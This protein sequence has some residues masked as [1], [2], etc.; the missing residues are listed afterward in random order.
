MISTTGE[1]A[2][3]AV[4]FLAQ[5]AGEAKTS[6][7]IADATKVPQGYLSKVMQQLAKADIVASQRGLH[8]GFTLARPPVSI[9]VLEVLKAVD[10]APERIHRCP[11]GIA[12]HTR[13]CPVH[14]LV[15]QAMAK[16]EAAFAKS[17]LA[18]L[19]RSTEGIQALC[20]APD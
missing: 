14:A 18:T 2:L 6:A 20:A 9:N 4:V 15:D 1:Y 17:D 5:H 8:G 16:V 10:A 13:L 11:L 12:G 3:R 19:A 7:V